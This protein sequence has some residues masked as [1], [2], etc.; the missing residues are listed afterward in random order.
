MSCNYKRFHDRTDITALSFSIFS[1]MF[2]DI[3]DAAVI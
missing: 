3:S 2:P 1:F